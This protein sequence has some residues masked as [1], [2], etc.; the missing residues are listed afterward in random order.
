VH[1]HA[2]DKGDPVYELTVQDQP[3]TIYMEALLW[4]E[5]LK[6]PMTILGTNPGFSTNR[7]DQ[8]AP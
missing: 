2:S 3:L 1:N 5:N 7:A 4:Q 6:E 8:G